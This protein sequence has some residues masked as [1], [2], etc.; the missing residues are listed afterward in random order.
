M[1]TK[2][3]AMAII[4]LSIAQGLVFADRQLDKAEILQ[5]FQKLTDQPR[6]TWIP[7]GTIKAAHQEYESS[8]GYT[9]DSTVIVKYD[10]DRFYWEINIDSHTKQ[11]EPEGSSPGKSSQYGFD[12][13][14]NKRRVFAW[15]GERH[16]MYFRPGNDAIVTEGPSNIPVTVNGPLTAGIIPWGYGVYTLQ[17]LS[18]AESSAQVDGRGQVHLTV[19][20]EI[21]KLTVEMAFVLDPTKDYAVLSYS[22]NDGGISSISKTYEDYKLVSGRWIPTTIIIDQYDNRKQPPELLSYDEWNLTSINVSPPQ[23]DWFSVA[24]ET[25]ASVKYHPSI[26]NKA[27]WYDSSNEVDI[28]SLLHDRLEIV[29][30][31]HTQR[32]NCATMAMK[33]VLG[34]LGK[35]VD[36]S[37]LAARLPNEPNEGTSLHAMKEFVQGLGLYCLAVKTDI[38]TLKNLKGCQVIL[39]LPGPNHY[40]VLDHIDDEYVWVID[41]DSNRFYYRTKLDEFGWDW[42]D[43]TALLISKTPLLLTG[44]FTE[45]VDNELRQIIGGFPTFS[46]T[47]VIQEEDTIFC[48]PPIGLTCGG[49]YYSIEELCGCIPDPNGGSC[50]GTAM[51]AYSYIHCYIDPVTMNTCIVDGDIYGRYMRAC[52]CEW[53][54]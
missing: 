1:K 18:A 39:H 8:H 6:K 14:W 44:T 27:L 19:F 33:Y 48:S 49:C 38:Q 25:G 26:T 12:L 22:L 20:M 32:Q 35:D 3:F 23:P 51:L 9:I 24:Y 36:D 15:D 40:V 43:G 5:I 54:E 45:V 13:N 17:S 53:W 11:T 21:N 4:L 2:I 50:T 28:D 52:A 16:T 31:G 34:Q 37:N 30:S 47:D 46:C 10:G 42:S 29:L 7:A 41:L